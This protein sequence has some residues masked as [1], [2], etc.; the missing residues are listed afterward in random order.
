MKI[1]IT[2]DLEEKNRRDINFHYG[3]QGLATYERCKSVCMTAVDTWLAELG[4]MHEM[5]VEAIKQLSLEV[6]ATQQSC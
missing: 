4:D 1:R 3:R 6:E 2:F 5:E